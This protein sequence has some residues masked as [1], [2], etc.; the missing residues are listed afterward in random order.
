V[1]IA[2]EA[3]VGKT[4]LVRRFAD[5]LPAGAAAA[6]ACD[7]L[8][9]PRPLGPLLD[10]A[11]ELAR[12][13]GR[14]MPDTAA[15]NDLLAFI[16]EALAPAADPPLLVFED[17]HWADQATIDLLR[18]VG[19]RLDRVRALILATL[20]EDEVAARSPVAVLLGDLATAG[21]VTRLAVPPLTRQGTAELV[22]GTGLDPDRTHALTGGNPFYIGEVVGSAGGG[23]PATVRDAVLARVS[24]QSDS[25]RRALE[26]AAAIGVRS[27]PALLA[28]VVER[29]GAGR[30]GL[31][32]A[33]DAGFLVRD[34][35]GDALAFRHELAR[36]AI[37]EATEPAERQRLHALVLDELRRRHGAADPEELV[38]HA[39]AAGD[40]ATVLE[41]APLAAER[42]S[43]LGAH[44]E[45]AALLGKAIERSD[46][47]RADLLERRAN[48]L[49]LSGQLAAASDVHHEA[50]RVRAEGHDARGQA[51]N[52]VRVSALCFLTGRYDE[53]ERTRQDALEILEALPPGPELARAYEAA[54]RVRYM[55]QDSAGA[56]ALAER[57]RAVAEAVGDDLTALDAR[58]TAGAAGL[59]SGDEAALPALEAALAEARAR[60]LED[61]AARAVLYLGWIPIL[62][63]SYENVEARLAE[64]HAHAVERE[65]EYWEQLVASARVRWALDQCVWH[66]VEPAAR[67]LLARPDVVSLARAQAL[68]SW[69]RLRARRGEAGATDTL[70][71]ALAVAREHDRVEP[72]ARIWPARMEAAWLAGRADRVLATAH[73]AA[74]AGARL[75]NAWW[76]GE[77]ALWVHLAGGSAASPVE[78]AP[79]Y[80]RSLAGDWDGA[81]R[82]WRDR[83]CRYEAAIALLL[84]PE[85]EP[86]E[87][88]LA[89]FDQLGARPAADR[90]RRRLRELGVTRVPRGPR[91][92]TLESPAGLT[93]REHD[94]L[95]LVAAGLSNPEIAHRLFLSP[96]TVE[97]HL[98]GILRKLDAGTRLEAAAIAGRRG[99]LH[100]QIGGAP[101]KSGDGG[102]R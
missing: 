79:P 18:Y 43:R 98:S 71:A 9:T 55:E 100:P 5:E 69:G 51:A 47:T 99:L 33:V 3:G 36:A 6:G 21:G 72:V 25:A 4:A 66:E 14:P 26:A 63:R 89:V 102:G 17:V 13:A 91:P 50:A 67:G 61:V 34:E 8:E 46:G 22:R 83:G 62:V 59:Q 101:R 16:A 12:R 53:C 75:D 24:R 87:A 30:W 57:A 10:M 39:E 15:R 93:R 52:L 23:V 7:P 32:E 48:E 64:G 96:K 94:V 76:H 54:S 68:V 73:E 28:R 19:R 95:L 80:A 42:A 38:R 77:A 81:A 29:G 60:G 11:P 58:V 85:P 20:R 56:L 31:Q 49:Y 88:A 92:S 44:R 2:G 82:W 45:A 97:R 40:D 86:V 37:A 90:A 27:A 78:P 41:Q 74:E 65:L 70:D 84:A 1:F 35:P